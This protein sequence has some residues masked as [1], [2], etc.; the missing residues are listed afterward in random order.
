MARLEEMSKEE[1]IREVHRVRPAARRFGDLVAEQEPGRLV[2]DLRAHQVE[3]E[4]QNRELRETQSLIE[5]SRNRYCDLYDF[6]PVGYCTLDSQGRIQDINLTGA[7]LLRT[8]RDRLADLPLSTFIWAED[9]PSFR[10]HLHECGLGNGR[11][12]TEVRLAIEGRGALVAQLV[13]IPLRDAGA[14]VAG[15]RTAIVDITTLTQFEDRLRFLADLGDRLAWSL[16]FRK[17]VA[18]VAELAVPFLADL[19]LIDLVDD[20]GVCKRVEA[21]F[22]DRKKQAKQN[23]RTKQSLQSENRLSPRA[24]VLSSGDP[25]LQEELAESLFEELANGDEHLRLLRPIGPKSLMIVALRTGGGVVGTLTFATSESGRRYGADDLVF[26]QEIARRASMAMD[27]ARLH[28]QARRAV[29]AREDLLAVVSHDLRNPLSVILVSATLALRAWPPGDINR[30]A[31][32]AIRR[33]ALR[34]DRLIGDLLD[35]STIEAGRLSLET[36]VQSV[37]QVVRDAIEA[38]EAP[39]TQKRVR[40]EAVGGGD[41]GVFCDRGRMLQVFSNLIG[42]AIKFT[43]EGGSITVRVEPR[44]QDVWFYVTDTGPGIPEDQLPR[45]FDRFWQA[46][47]TARLGTGLGLDDR[48]GNHRGA[49]R[50]HRSGERARRGQHVL[51]HAASREPAE[52]EQR[53]RLAEGQRRRAAR[54]PHLGPASQGRPRRRRRRRLARGDRRDV[55]AARIRSGL[56]YQRRRGAR[57][58][59][60]GAGAVRRVARSGDAREGRVVLSRRAQSRLCPA[61]DSGHRRVRP[62]RRRRASRRGQR[63]L[64]AQAGPRREPHRGHRPGLEPMRSVSAIRRESEHKKIRRSGRFGDCTRAV[65]NAESSLE[66][67]SS[68]TL[69]LPDLPDLFVPPSPPSAAIGKQRQLTRRPRRVTAPTLRSSQPSAKLRRTKCRY[70]SRAEKSGPG[71]MLIPSASARR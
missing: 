25:V 56:R 68:T 65:I 18:A 17:I 3:L 35:A 53:P 23:E 70:F 49:G 69:R 37:D 58:P 43:P 62:A 8:S 14:R 31:I 32:E 15:Y 47:R 1:L 61:V 59:A 4:M 71:A 9:H 41:L 42:N 2:R 45:L 24:T 44:D 54:R 11:V 7:A 16:D 21:V 46:K 22:A 38:L 39:A 34:M 64:P 66:A 48:Q 6:A 63:A 20:G 50:P 40:L 19:C 55:E 60:P 36:A 67:R 26:A 28:E 51:L 30:R 57:V 12:A 5:S 10:S 13:S 52:P 27:N 33:S 29:Q